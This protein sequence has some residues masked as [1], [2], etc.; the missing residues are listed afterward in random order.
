MSSGATI[1]SV[2]REFKAQPSL[3][4]SFRSSALWS[5]LGESGD[6]IF[7]GAGDSYAVSL[8][9][10]FLAGPRVLALDP[11]S[12]AESIGW[13]RGKPVFVVSISGETRSNVEL[14]RALKGV[15]KLTVAVTSNPESRLAAAADSVVELPFKPRGKS[16]GIAS[17]TLALST[18]LKVCG[19]EYDCDFEEVL[20]RAATAAKGIRIANGR[21]LTHFAGNNE[22]YA[23]SV[24]GVA[25]IY[26]MLGGRAQASLLEEFSHMPLFSLFK[27]DCVNIVESPTGRKGGE[28]QERLTKGGYSSSLIRLEGD[29]V[30]R[31]Y[32]LVFSLQK[33]VIDAARRR[34]LESPYFLGAKKKMKI[35]DEMIY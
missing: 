31:L 5:E 32:L 4:R 24:Y 22:A 19:L 1:A 33:A 3:L 7:V 6:L 18:V 27:S 13:A 26:E 28:L 17:F 10:S 9:A 14:A 29:P 23:A 35:S 12:L 20:A 11:Y 15:A 8:C 30:E 34:G 25:K 21:N 2:N 16:P